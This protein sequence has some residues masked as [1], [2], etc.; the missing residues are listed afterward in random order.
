[1]LN[2]NGSRLRRCVSAL[3][4]ASLL[5]LPASNCF[6]W[7]PG[8]HMMTAQIAFARLNPRARAELTRLIAIP[9][10][11]SAVTSRSLDF[12]TASVWADDVKRLSGFEFSGDEHFAD[13]PFRV[14]RTRLP[15]LPKDANVLNALKRYVGVLRTSTDDNERAQAL[16]F[17]IHY[18]GDIHQPLHCS[19]RVDR[20][21]PQ[22]D[23][24][25]N[26]FLVS[27]VRGRRADVKLHS[28]W[29]SGLRTFPS[30]GI[31]P[32]PM[33]E[34]T[35]AVAAVLREN[36]DTDPDIHLDRPEDFDGWARESS[37]LAQESA[38]DRLRPGGLVSMT[39]RRDG[40]VVARR[41]VAWG[42]YR[43]AALLNSL[44]PAS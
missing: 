43:L 30:R 17:V 3:V 39:Y 19:T 38:Y 2:R 23:Q 27:L 28:F 5:L 35:D 15:R 22:G 21:H 44:F 29:D 20:R 8:G 32:P 31:S 11:P 40:A 12:V 25:G 10:R 42:G 1:M 9:I 33:N 6:A 37:A 41:R 4:L 34:I 26:L 36:P 13:F 7:G 16:R 14:D 24:G 18:V